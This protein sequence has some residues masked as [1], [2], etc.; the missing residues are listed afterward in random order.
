MKKRNYWP[1][2]FIGIFSFAFGMIVWTI[3]SAVKTPVHEDYAFLDKYQQVEEKFNDFVESNKNFNEKFNI[4][5]SLNNNNFG[6]E[7]KDI[8]MS[9]RVLNEKSTHKNF[10]N[11]GKNS[12]VVSLKDKSGKDIPAL[13]KFKVTKATNNN[14]DQDISN[15]ESKTMDFHFDITHAGNWN[16]TG[17]IEAEGQ[18]GYFFIKSNAPN[19]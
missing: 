8:Y 11:V 1:L 19:R 10:F 3:I 2:F 14:F 6:L 4:V 16:I 15:S 9:Q 12:L 18:K 5:I 13:I 7:I 17:T